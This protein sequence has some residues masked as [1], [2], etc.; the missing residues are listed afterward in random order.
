MPWRTSRRRA[1]RSW[2][3]V[4]GVTPASLLLRYGPLLAK[5]LPKLAF[6]L[7][8]PRTRERL[9]GLAGDVASR[10]PSKRLRARV[11]ATAIMAE[12]YGEQ[13]ASEEERAA[14]TAWA[15]EARRLRSRLEVPVQGRRAGKEH[16]DAVRAD[17]DA[18]QARINAALSGDDAAG[19][20]PAADALTTGAAPAGGSAE[21]LPRLVPPF[22]D[23][24]AQEVHDAVV[25]GPRGSGPQAFSLTAPDG[26][27]RGPF[28]LMLHAPHL[29][30]PLQA[31]GAAVRY[32][33]SFGDRAREVAILTVAAVRGSDFERWA[34]ERI[35][36]QVG[37]DDDDL[38][39][40][41]DLTFGDRP[42]VDA[43]EASVHRVAAA[44]AANITLDETA[45]AR[46]RDALGEQA[47]LELVVLVGYY[48]TL[49]SMMAVFGVGAPDEEG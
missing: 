9:L 41:R 2:G 4:A 43:H 19:S 31:L 25:G 28:G 10:T 26:S 11:D 27:L 8:D 47:L 14:A 42:W 15:R 7:A 17:L 39:G 29:G 23:P 35:G 45:Y 3:R 38:A 49:A 22:D 6:L 36:A 21:R 40:I 18:L 16:L 46:A 48:A 24:R 32:E 37:L 30:L 20:T 12:S 33:T 13:A 34:H 1:R 5:Q 44:L